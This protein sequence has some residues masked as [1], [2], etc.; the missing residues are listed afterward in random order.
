MLSQQTMKRRE[1][2]LTKTS[3]LMPLNIV[4]VTNNSIKRRI[5][6]QLR[7]RYH[8]VITSVT[9]ITVIVQSKSHIYWLIS[10]SVFCAYV[11]IQIRSFKLEP[12][13]SYS[14]SDQCFVRLLKACSEQNVQTYHS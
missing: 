13:F 3:H 1:Y 2:Y 9:D 6:N 7:N 8:I 10:N 5:L 14:F 11:F 4:H 12:W